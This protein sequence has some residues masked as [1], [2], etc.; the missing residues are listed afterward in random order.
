MIIANENY[1]KSTKLHGNYTEI[2]NSSAFNT[3]GTVYSQTE[4]TTKKQKIKTNIGKYNGP[5]KK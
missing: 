2:W 5:L 4:T 1:R 3:V